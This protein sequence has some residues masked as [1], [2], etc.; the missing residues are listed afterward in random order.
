MMFGA[1]KTLLWDFFKSQLHSE[2]KLRAPGVR[3]QLGA[4]APELDPSPYSAPQ[5]ARL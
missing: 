2:G 4:L 1:A 3:Q 5:K